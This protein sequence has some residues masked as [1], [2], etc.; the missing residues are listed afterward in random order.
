[1]DL[2]K[3]KEARRLRLKR[4]VPMRFKDGPRTDSEGHCTDRT[5]LTIN[6]LGQEGGGH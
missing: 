5:T 2:A 3:I 6:P 4:L 1:M